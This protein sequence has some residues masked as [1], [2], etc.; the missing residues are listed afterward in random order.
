MIEEITYMNKTFDKKFVEID[1]AISR[2]ARY[3]AML[4]EIDMSKPF[5]TG[6]TLKTEED[7]KR[8]YVTDYLVE[9]KHALLNQLS[10]TI[11]KSNVEPKDVK[12]FISTRKQAFRKTI[13]SKGLSEKEA[14]DAMAEIKATDSALKKI[15]FDKV[16]SKF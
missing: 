5:R 12:M 1:A 6:V 4:T 14:V 3:E 13:Q 11:Q 9:N 8:D 2:V 15:K 7:R 16:I 10:E